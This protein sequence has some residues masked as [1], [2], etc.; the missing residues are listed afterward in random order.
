MATMK[1]ASK[2]KSDEQVYIYNIQICKLKIKFA[3][4]ANK[5]AAH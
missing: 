1:V 5:E 2:P 4:A 3:L